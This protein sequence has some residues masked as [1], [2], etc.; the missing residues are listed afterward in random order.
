MRVKQLCKAL[1]IG[2]LG[3]SLAGC[4]SSIANKSDVDNILSESASS[5]SSKDWDDWSNGVN[6]NS[7]K[8]DY[9]YY[10]SASGDVDGG[11]D[12]MIA[13]FEKIEKFVTDN[14]G[15]VDRV[16]NDYSGSDDSYNYYGHYYGDLEYSESGYLRFTILIDESKIADVTEFI[17]DIIKDNNFEVNSYEQYVQNYEDYRIVDKYDD[18][19]DPYSDRVITQ[20]DLDDALKYSEYTVNLIYLHARTFPEKL[21][22]MLHNTF[23]DILGVG[24]WLLVINLLLFWEAKLFYKSFVKLQHKYRVKHPELYQPRHVVIDDGEVS[25]VKTDTSEDVDAGTTSVTK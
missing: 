16:E 7:P 13:D 9:S 18:E 1:S 3:I 14:D 12:K 11:R 22:F 5:V 8:A 21:G 6:V 25:Y 20:E 24:L 17:G 2:L 15:I 4:S 10:L 23:V 19:Y